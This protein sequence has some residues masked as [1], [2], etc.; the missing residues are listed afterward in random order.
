ML[1]R[2]TDS[3]ALCASLALSIVV[4]KDKNMT[5][6]RLT[7]HAAMF[8]TALF[9]L[10]LIFSARCQAQTTDLVIAPVAPAS[11]LLLL[12]QHAPWATEQNRRGLIPGD[13]MLEH[14]ILVLKRSPQKQKAFERF[15]QELQDASSPSYHR[16]LTPVQVGKRFGTSQHDIEAVTGWL[17]SQGLRLNS[18]GNSRMMIDFSGNAS[19]VGA[20]F[21]TKMSYYEVKGERRMATASDP[22]IPA[23]LAGVIQSVSGL[24]TANDHPYYGAQPAQVPAIGAGTELPALSICNGGTCTNFVA[25]GDF[26][27]IYDLSGAWNF[28]LLGG[29]QTIAIIGRAKVYDPDIENFQTLSGLAKQDPTVIVPPNGMDP[30]APAGTGGTATGDQIEA[31]LDVMRAGSVAPAATID[32]VVSADDEQSGLNGIR[33]AATYVVDTNPLPAYIMNISFG[34]CE[35]DRTQADVQFWDTLFSQA[36]AEGIS[37]FVASGDGGAAGCDDYFQPPPQNQIASPNY[38]CSSSYSTCVGG[39]EFADTSNPS[40]YWSQSGSGDLGSALGYIPEG[41][42]N[43]P[44]NAQGATQAASSGGGFSS[45]IPTPSWQVGTG[46]PGTQGRYT[47]DV[48]FSSSAH[49]GYFGCLAASGGAHP[50]DCV[51]R[52]GEFYFEYFF[53]TSA[54]APDMAGIT[55]LLNQKFQSP[56]GELNQR[57]YYLAANP[58]LKVFNDVT[59]DTSGVSG[60]AVTTPSMCN[61]SMPS[62]TGLTGGLPGYLVTPG[63]DEVTGLGSIDVS[64]LLVN[65]YAGFPATTSVVTSSVNPAFQGE[66]VTFTATVTTAGT[67]LPTGKVTFFNANY[68]FPFGALGTGFLSTVNGT[69][70]A[71]FTTSTLPVDLYHITAFYSGDANNADSTSPE[72]IQNINAPTFT[73]AAKDSASG[74]VLSGQ[75]ATYNFM[76]TPTGISTFPLSISFGCTPIA[77]LTCT[78]NP[79]QIAAGSGSTPVQLTITTVGPNQ[80]TGSKIRRAANYRFP[81]LPLALPLSGIVMVGFARRRMSQRCAIASVFS[82]LVLL[83]LLVACGGGGGGNG[84]PPPPP[85]V[86]VT[87]SAGVPA[88]LFPNDTADNWPLQTAQFTATVTNA[89]NKAVTWAVSPPN[90]GTI[91]A[92]GLY[93]AATVAAGLPTSVAIT[94]TSVADP[95]KFGQ[96]TETLNAA[97][98]PTPIG[99]PYAIYVYAFEGNTVNNVPVT[100]AVE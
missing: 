96:A 25:P 66:P 90:L 89:N 88:S 51:V 47:P 72:V 82:C 61:N 2:H 18:V 76:A 40:Q 83:G 100:L 67:N 48:A 9:T 15:L 99:Q 79:A 32:L 10:L 33:T 4:S 98:I 28:D 42:W 1:T 74:S 24:N 56:Q 6:G 30:G 44:L 95:T 35:A 45:Y 70:V 73:W 39:T 78:F 59:V 84:A 22:Q 80:P 68:G 21:A 77:T 37:A 14:L 17:R 5:S 71:T 91:D 7:F 57:L 63:F 75:S 31:T 12:G 11:R 38:I 58:V 41:G 55:A 85:E 27:T 54:A 52:N 49:D 23:A 34:A 94:A 92:N 64:N 81:W 26:F 16:F 86:G 62:P 29:G 50:G 3:V 13:T 19:L 43:E 97:T 65:W 53:G 20:A 46:V 60:C 93:T 87:V 8:W 69:Q 36:A